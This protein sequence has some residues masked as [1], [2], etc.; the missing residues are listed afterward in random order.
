V[1]IDLHERLTDL[2]AGT[3][4]ASPPG[5]LWDRGVRRRRVVAAGRVAVA[6]VLV[7]LVGLGGWTWHSARPVQPADP[8]GSPHLPDHLFTPSPWLHSFDGPPGQLVALVSAQRK[9]LLHTTSG[10]VGVTASSGQYGFLDLPQNA[11]TG[12]GRARQTTPVLSPDGLHVA[13][14]TTGK[15]SGTPNTH[16]LGFTITGVAVYDTETGTVRTARLTTEHGLA[17]SLLTWTDD[18]TVVLAPDQTSQGDEDPDSCCAA[19][20]GGLATWD[21]SS[22]EG[23]TLPSSKLPISVDAYSAV[24][25]RGVL[26]EADSRQLQVINPESPGSGVTYRMSRRSAFAL[27][28]PDGKQVVSVGERYHAWLGTLPR[29]NR[30][31]GVPLRPLAADAQFTHPVAWLDDDHVVMQRRVLGRARARYSLALVDVRSGKT[32]GLVHPATSTRQFDPDGSQ[33]AR[34]LLGAPVVRAVAPPQPLDLRWVVWGSL[35]CLLVVGSYL[36]AA[37][38]DRRA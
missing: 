9:S 13:F 6:L 25:G 38:R 34:D 32:H 27:T 2:A 17:P 14:W 23:P 12:D 16:L 7:L 15:P 18:Q 21:I 11:V 8:H 35:V 5:D 19:H 28:S 3:P 10:I 24:A 37:S 26:V 29:A 4:S 33:Y 31:G 30:P 20:V 1:A 22:G 36:W